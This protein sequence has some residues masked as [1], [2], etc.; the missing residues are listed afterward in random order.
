MTK[1]KRDKSVL[2]F[3]S[4]AVV[5]LMLMAAA[6]L[7]S[8]LPATHATAVPPQISVGS[9]TG[10]WHTNGSQIVDANGQPVRITGINWF[11]METSTFVP[12]GLWARNWADMLDQ[13]KSLGYNTL[14]LPFCNQAFDPGST[15]NSIDF[16]RN[17]DLAGLN[18]LQI[19]DKIV[20]RAGEIGLRIFLDRHRP[21]S[22]SQS[23]LWYTSQF[24]EQRWIDDWRMLAQRYRN[25]PTV[26]GADLHNEPH[27]PACWGCGDTATDWRL[28]AERAGNAILQ[29]NPDW[30]IIVEGVDCFQND[31]T[32]WGG[33]LKGATSFPV[34]LSVPNKL[35]YSPHEYATS[36]FVQPWF[37]DPSFPNNLGPIWEKNWGF[38]RTQ[39]IAP[40]LVGEFGSRLQ[41]QRDRQ[42]LPLLLDYMGQGVT[43]MGFTFWT[44]NP[45]SGDTGGI[46]NDDW[47]TVDNNKHS[48]LA[49]FLLG[50]FPP[51]GSGPDFTLSA[52]PASVN[53]NRGASVTTTIN[54]TR[55]G[56]FTGSVAFS[57]SGLPTGV[58]A[59]FNPS[60]TSANSTTLTLSASTNAP[61][62]TTMIN[63]TGAGGGLTRS[64]VIGLVV[65]SAPDFSLARNPSSL[66]I[67]RGAS[68]TSSITITRT[69]GF[70][71]SVAFSAS[72]L[73]AGV[74]ASFNPSSTTGNSSTLTLTASSTATTGQSTVT[75]TGAGGGLTRTTTISLTVNAPVPDFSLSVSP[76]SLTLTQ[77]TAG[78]RSI[79]IARVN[80]F[81]SSVSLSA[82]GL[83]SGVTA[84]FNPTSTAG[85]SSTLTLTASATASTGMATV[86]VTGAGGGL[87]RTVAISL[88]VS[89]AGG[90]NGGVT[91]TPVINAS[92][93]WFNEEAIR[94]DNTGVLTA[95]SITIVIQRTTGVG[96]NGQYN[97]VGGQI[98]QSSSSTTTTITYQFTLAAGQTIGVGT[99][100]LFAA[101]TG[102][103]GTVHPT[104]GDTFTITYTVGGQAFSQSGHF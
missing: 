8:S 50:P 101:Q 93:P 67:N 91:V 36:V 89:S 19:L 48:F 29:V 79:N 86:T 74:T 84:S 49:P 15:P 40:V 45:N 6:L 55:G 24:S 103:G 63:V 30:L 53:V 14:R 23:A 104:A 69:G 43:G 11:G 16:N 80:G 60:S 58:T 77:G 82:S 76:A 100:R 18:S 57:A 7:L 5:L 52:S 13:V 72:G 39:N 21:D 70:T 51:V 44:L 64:T 10:F 94:L 32:W 98:S 46:L 42:W 9:G 78:T 34:R 2:K 17:P 96:F 1:V 73:P 25:N 54:I 102:G 65:N 33:Q 37:N 35:V 87:T 81:T 95:L 90:G 22:G 61:A 62:G 4:A 75:V 85:N 26:V 71:S 88:S 27:G 31:C 56:G 92:G 47:T 97:T 83:P 99:N 41:D 38:L 68:G 66:T 20:E 59:S 28:A 12:H 3:S